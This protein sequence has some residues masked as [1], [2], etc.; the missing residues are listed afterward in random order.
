[1]ALVNTFNFPLMALP[2]A[3]NVRE[4]MRQALVCISI[5]ALI[6]II[7]PLEAIT[8]KWLMFILVVAVQF[9]FNL[10]L[11]FVLARIVTVWNDFTHII[12]FSVRIWMYLS[13]IFYG[14]ER[15]EDMPVVLNLMYAH[16]LF[17]ILDITRDLIL[18]DSWPDPMR[19]IVL[20]IWTVVMLIA[21]TILFWQADES[22]GR[23]R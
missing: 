21:G 17:C 3:V 10:G 9:L 5:F 8:W 11:S 6:L 22:D 2:I 7:T 12:A 15:F 20:G 4:T 1:L 19:W 14:V 13:A 16:P 18:Y 23:E